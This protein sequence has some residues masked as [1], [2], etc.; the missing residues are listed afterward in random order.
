MKS[1]AMDGPP[2]TQKLKPVIA[3]E[4]SHHLYKFR[5]AVHSLENDHLIEKMCKRG[6]VKR[7]PWK[8]QQ[9][10]PNSHCTLGGE[11][12]VFYSKLGQKH[13]LDYAW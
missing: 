7:Q 13:G 4:Q 2:M 8:A 11:R 12:Q 1:A 6:G 3:E 10:Q 5:P 9:R